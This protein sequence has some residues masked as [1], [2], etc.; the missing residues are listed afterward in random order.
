MDASLLFEIILEIHH[1]FAIDI[2]VLFHV[3]E[4][5]KQ[6][7]IDVIAFDG[8]IT[9]FIDN[10]SVIHEAIDMFKEMFFGNCLNLIH[11]LCPFCL[12]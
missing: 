6:L 8:L 12:T 7:D 2:V 1:C 5:S 4:V 11:C 3:E 9:G 10:F